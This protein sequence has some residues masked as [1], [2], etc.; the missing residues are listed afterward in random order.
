MTQQ[1]MSLAGGPVA[2]PAGPGA[3]IGAYL[4]DLSLVIGLGLATLP[5]ANSWLIAAVVWAEGAVVLT[6][7]RAATGRTPGSLLVRMVGFA[8]GSD[9][10]P[11]LGRQSLRTA[12]Q[13]ALQLTVLGP[14]ISAA[15]TRQGQD[16]ADRVAGTAAATVSRTRSSSGTDPMPIGAGAEATWTAP[17]HETTP[18]PHSQES[19]APH[20]RVSTPITE[21]RQPGQVAPDLPP[22]TSLPGFSP[23]PSPP[24]IPVPSPVSSPVPSPMPR[25]TPSVAPNPASRPAS[26]PAASPAVHPEQVSPA[27]RRLAPPDQPTPAAQPAA[28]R[29]PETAPPAASALRA[30]VI[31]DSG[32]QIELSRTL[33]LGREPAARDTSEQ[34][35]P[36]SDPSM[37]LSR[38]HLRLGVDESGVWIEDAFSTNGTG[39]L[40]PDGQAVMLTQGQRVKVTNG[41]VVLLGD[42]RLTIAQLPAGS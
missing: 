42:Y 36:I 21:Y 28:V 9:H 19:V 33:V 18:P 8:T 24:Q 7:A 5:L 39:Y 6:L 38:T 37:S 23:Q 31:F 40:T 2:T 1:Q 27:P 26:P 14:V 35:V 4:A 25:Q 30:W 41:T 29:R 15:T 12:I 16:W 34:A 17:V 13:A 10:A 11:G 22:S 32:Q 20:N 3:R